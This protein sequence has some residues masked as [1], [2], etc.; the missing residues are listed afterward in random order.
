MSENINAIESTEV[1]ETNNSEV[2]EEKKPGLLTKAKE[3]FVKHKGTV[4]KLAILSAVTAVA[5]TLG[6]K[7]R[8]A[9]ED[10]LDDDE[11]V[12]GEFEETDDLDESESEE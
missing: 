2:V 6:R 1:V 7:T 11:T 3:T 9:Y 4:K 8:D 12:E 5:F 10:D